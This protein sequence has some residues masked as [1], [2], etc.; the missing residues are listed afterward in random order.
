MQHF[1]TREDLL[2]FFTVIDAYFRIKVD[3]NSTVLSLEA[4]TITPSP[5]FSSQYILLYIHINTR[6][7]C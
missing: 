2:S 7:V 3:A 4:S 6:P 5:Q 1:K